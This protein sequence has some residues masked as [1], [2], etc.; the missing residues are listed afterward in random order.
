M[1]GAV[2]VGG[3]EV[4][5]TGDA[6]IHVRFGGEMDNV[7]D[8]MLADDAKDCCL[9]A[10]IDLLKSVTRVC[11]VNAVEIFEM[12]GVGEAVEIDERGDFRP[13]NDVPDEIGAD[14]A[15]PA[16][17]EKIHAALTAA[18]SLKMPMRGMRRASWKP[19]A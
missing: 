14:E 7:G 5:G 11:A 9:V 19:A 18:Y 3:D 15:C 6:A 12:T 1:E 8:V 4:A 10:E 2:D 13:V 17:D 16:G